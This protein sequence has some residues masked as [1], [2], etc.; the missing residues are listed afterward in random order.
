MTKETGIYLTPTDRLSQ[1]R[2][3]V[4][5]VPVYTERYGGW[6]YTKQGRTSTY[7]AMLVGWDSYTWKDEISPDI[8]AM[9][10]FSPLGKIG[11]LLYVKETYGYVTLPEHSYNPKI[12]SHKRRKDGVPVNVYYKANAIKEGW[13]DDCPWF[14]PVTMPKKYA[15]YWYK[16]TGLRVERVG[17]I[18]YEDVMR[19]STNMPKITLDEGPVVIS[20]FRTTWNAKH[21]DFPFESNCWTWVAEIERIER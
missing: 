15:R 20:D 11:D 17:D 10:R 18:I 7:G 4:K 3:P 1:Y 21:P 13:T 8:E 16:I 5:P 9:S 2:V 14:S 12:A 19:K 6:C